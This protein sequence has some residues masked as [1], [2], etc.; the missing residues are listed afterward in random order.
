MEGPDY[1]FKSGKDKAIHPVNVGRFGSAP[2]DKV[3]AADREHRRTNQW[4]E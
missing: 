3:N 2:M 4:Q 1:R